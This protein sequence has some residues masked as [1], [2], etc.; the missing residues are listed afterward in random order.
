VREAAAQLP[1]DYQEIQLF[2]DSDEISA[3]EDDDTDDLDEA[4]EDAEP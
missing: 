2:G 4:P 3:S 1:D